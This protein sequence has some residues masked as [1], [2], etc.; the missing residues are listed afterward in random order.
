MSKTNNEAIIGYFNAQGESFVEGMLLTTGRSGVYH[1]KRDLIAVINASP[2]KQADIRIVK[3][4]IPVGS[5]IFNSENNQRFGV[6]KGK[7]IVNKV[8]ELHK[9]LE[10]EEVA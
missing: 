2:I 10:L 1:Q 6:K 4:T 7:A 5:A 3:I 9:V 8:T